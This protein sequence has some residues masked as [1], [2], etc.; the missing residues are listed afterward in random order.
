M[1]KATRIASMG[2]KIVAG[3]LVVYGFL[4]LNLFMIALGIFLYFIAG[5]SYDQMLITSSLTHLKIKEVMARKV[6]TVSLDLSIAD[7]FQNF[8]LRYGA[9][10]ALVTKNK[11]FHG[12]ITINEFEKIPKQEWSKVKVKD[13]LVPASKI[14]T[15]KES[16]SALKTLS[17]M[18]KQKI[19]LM[20]VIKNKKLIGAVTIASLLRYAQLDQKFKKTP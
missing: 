4:T 13:V 3:L 14:P 17:K 1:R 19:N 8:F 6:R 10:G 15:A 11:V 5:A 7:L 18:S 2:G 9:E 16:D 20:P 12:I